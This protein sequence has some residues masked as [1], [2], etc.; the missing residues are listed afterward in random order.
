MPTFTFRL[1]ILLEQK[2]ELEKQARAVVS[3][4]DRLLMQAQQALEKLR[5]REEGIQK[6]LRDISSRLLLDDQV[7]QA[8]AVQRRNNYREALARDLKDAHEAALA[9]RYIVEEAEE[10]LTRALT[11]AAECTREV[12]K[13]E[14][15]RDKQ[16]ARFLAEAERKEQ[17][18]Q[19]ELG[20]VMYLSRRDGN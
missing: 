17:L 9:Q 5:E 19:D 8:L 14:K 15:Y 4:K 20:T 2:L 11:Y 13:L 7:N 12:E 16:E 18:E 3:E 6:Q 1:Q 10:E